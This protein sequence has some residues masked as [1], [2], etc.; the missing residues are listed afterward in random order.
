MSRL[1]LKLLD[2]DGDVQQVSV[3]G[4]LGNSSG[5]YDAAETAAYALRDAILAV[6]LGAQKGYGFVADDVELS[7]AQPSDPFA[8]ANIQWIVAYT[9][10]VTAAK[11]TMRIGTADLSLADSLYNGAPALNIGAGGAGNALAT[12]FEAYVQND[13]HAVTVDAIYFRE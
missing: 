9:D 4:L 13:G 7:P 8:Q 1:V 10:D 5:A 11:R 12:A 2:H 6:T 3:P